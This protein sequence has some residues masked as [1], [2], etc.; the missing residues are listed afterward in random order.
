MDEVKV[1]D[2]GKTGKPVADATAGAT[3]IDGD[4]KVLANGIDVDG[5]NDIDKLVAFGG[6]SFSILDAYGNRVFDSGDQI[7]QIIKATEKEA[8]ADIDSGWTV[9]SPEPRG[10]AVVW[11]PT[12]EI[13]LRSIAAEQVARSRCMAAAA[14]QS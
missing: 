5:D 8:I 1:S 9:T 10:I 3:L 12:P 6:R 7:E 13:G 11:Y 4:L 2:L 14:P